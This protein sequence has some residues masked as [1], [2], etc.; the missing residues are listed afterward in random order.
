MFRVHFPATSYL[1]KQVKFFGTN[2][3][4]AAYHK[5]LL[6]SAG[7]TF[8]GRGGHEYHSWAPSEEGISEVPDEHDHPPWNHDP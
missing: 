5:P 3:F 6:K 2:H 4:L 1:K 7:L 8:V